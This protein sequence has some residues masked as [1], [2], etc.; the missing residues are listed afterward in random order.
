[1]IYQKQKSGDHSVNIQAGRDVVFNFDIN[2]IAPLMRKQFEE[3][4]E[5][6]SQSDNSIKS[7]IISKINSNQ[8]DEAR[9]LTAQLVEEITQKASQ[10]FLDIANLYS[11]LEP[12]KSERFYQK[13]I[14]ENPES[15]EA[16]N[17]YAVYLMNSGDLNKAEKLFNSSLTNIALPSIDREKI[18]GNLGVLYKNNGEFDKSIENLEN[19]IVLSKSNKNKIG[20]VKHLNNLG[21]C[22]NNIEEYSKA[23]LCL[24][25]SLALVSDLLEEEQ[26]KALKKEMRRIKSNILTNIAI[27]LRYLWFKSPDREYL[28]KAEGVL[29]QAIDIAELLEEEVELSRHYGNISNIYRQ[30]GER[31]KCME[32]IQK[33]L[34]LSENNNDLRGEVCGLLNI[35][36]AHF[37][38][39]DNAIAKEY[40]EKSLDKE[41]NQ[42]PKLKAHIFSNLA[43][44]HKA[45]G[46]KSEARNYFD[47]AIE[48]YKKLG[49]NDSLLEITQSFE[50]N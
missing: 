42:Y 14:E 13:A 22:Y 40:F 7:E 38:D 32:Y 35:G 10:D 18:I 29:N 4:F 44:L 8:L 11:I 5:R 21:S 46:N 1:M 19:A 3:L 24:N 39:G 9:E 26:D 28:I 48:L 25:E 37:D 6:L 49:L 41:A 36:L 15:S 34:T 2:D 30:L 31:S 27:G 16:I 43:L 50:G 17:A 23:E 20:Q 47:K 33:S 12:S 45:D